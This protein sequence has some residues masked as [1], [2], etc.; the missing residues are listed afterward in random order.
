M[1]T[2]PI[3]RRATVVP[4]ISP[5]ANSGFGLPCE[6]DF[7]ECTAA[8]VG[9]QM[10]EPSKRMPLGL[11]PSIRFAGARRVRRV[12]GQSGSWADFCREGN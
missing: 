10:L 7:A 12:G 9:I 11:I 2:M 1:P 4:A 3:A 5:L 8:L 6:S